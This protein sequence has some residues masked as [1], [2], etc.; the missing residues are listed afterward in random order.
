M[1]RFGPSRWLSDD[2]N[3]RYAAFSMVMVA[4]IFI[5]LN[6]Y[7][8]A[9]DIYPITFFHGRFLGTTGNPQHAAVLLA[10]IL[11]CL[12]FVLEDQDQKWRQ[13]CVLI[14]IACVCLALLMTG[15]R[16]GMLM[17]IATLLFFYRNQKKSFFQMAIALCVV[18]AVAL[19]MILKD[20]ALLGA[21]Q[22][23][24]FS[25]FSSTENT[26]EEVW[27]ALWRTFNQYP[28]L[29]APLRGE[30]IVYGESSWLATAAN[31]GLVGLV[32]L[33]LFG[34]ACVKM[35][36]RLFDISK[37]QPVYYLQCSTVISGIACLLVGSFFEPFLLGNVSS[38]LLTMLLY[39][40]LGQYI[41]ERRK[42]QEHI[43]MRQQFLMESLL[44]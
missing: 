2:K 9:V 12:M 35:M 37:Q 26:R 17:T 4:I 28:I 3:F 31:L 11:P 1:I 36:I 41:L 7:Q 6:A 22:T 38:T 8:A 5:V 10:S 15:S 39:L 34:T 25:R 42:M 21:D 29:G 16:T 20:G 19:P 40:S 33:C 24:A 27:S 13:C 23:S 18:L 30:R 44:V 32:P 14:C 43:K